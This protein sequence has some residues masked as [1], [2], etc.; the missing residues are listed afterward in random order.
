MSDEKTFDATFPDDYQ[1]E[2]L[3]GKTASFSVVIKRL[4]TREVPELGDELAEDLG[5]D[6]MEEM[7]T[8]ITSDLSQRKEKSAREEQK[9][10]I[11]AQLASHQVGGCSSTHTPPPSGLAWGQCLAASSAARFACVTRH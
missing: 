9:A 2:A 6:S 7:K 3:A 1:S 4:M 10:A 11:A 5:F 8:K